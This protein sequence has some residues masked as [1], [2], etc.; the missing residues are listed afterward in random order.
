M[1]SNSRILGSLA[2]TLDAE[3]ARKV[4]KSSR[5]DKI[6]GKNFFM[7]FLLLF[8]EMDKV[9]ALCTTPKDGELD[10]GI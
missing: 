2:L 8:G 6:T 10:L 1:V 4:L 5:V 7:D 9:P 3:L